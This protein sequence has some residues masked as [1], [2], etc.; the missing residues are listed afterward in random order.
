MLSRNADSYL[1]VKSKKF[2]DDMYQETGA[3]MF[4]MAVYKDK[5]GDIIHAV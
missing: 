5:E 1:A 4:L 3:R 2:V